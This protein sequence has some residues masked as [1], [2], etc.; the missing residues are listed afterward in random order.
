M[1]GQD[2]G[3]GARL[4]ALDPDSGRGCK[5]LTLSSSSVKWRSRQRKARRAALIIQ[6][7]EA[8]G[9]GVPPLSQ[10]FSAGQGWNPGPGGNGPATSRQMGGPC[11]PDPW[12][13]AA[14]SDWE[15]CGSSTRCPRPLLW[16]PP[17]GP[18]TP[19]GQSVIHRPPPAPHP[20]KQ[21][22][23][24]SRLP[25]C[26]RAESSLPSWPSQVHPGK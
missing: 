6:W 11:L 1:D 17:S 4:S 18:L 22:A 2:C 14:N 8:C 13:G 20:G 26:L 23:L 19:E 12:A 5:S 24:T 3:P 7:A 15:P 16:S 9:A 21:C 10:A 25:S